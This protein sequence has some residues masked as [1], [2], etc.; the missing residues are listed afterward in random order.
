MTQKAKNI[1]V[2]CI[3]IGF[4]VYQWLTLGSVTGDY[5][6]A[7][8]Y[9][10]GSCVLLLICVAIIFLVKPIDNKL[11][12]NTPSTTDAPTATDEPT[13]EATPIAEEVVVEEPEIELTEEEKA[14]IERKNRRNKIIVIVTLICILGYIIGVIISA[15]IHS[16]L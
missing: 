6:Y 8:G 14:E 3:L 7:L 12:T 5:A 1:L 13:V 2:S 9:T 11:I 15:I 16:T 4:V 10:A